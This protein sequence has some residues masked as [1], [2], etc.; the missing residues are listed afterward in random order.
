ME[1]QQFCENFGVKILNIKGCHGAFKT[2]DKGILLLGEVR[3]L[4]E[5]VL[6]DWERSASLGNQFSQTGRVSE[7]L[8]P[9]F[10][11][12]S[13]RVVLSENW[14]WIRPVPNGN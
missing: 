12:S 6:L 14:F 11:T 9:V 10:K 5:L 8:E 13:T 7:C 3:K 1:I 4:R 2:K